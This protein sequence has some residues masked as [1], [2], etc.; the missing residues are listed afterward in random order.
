MNEPTEIGQHYNI[1]IEKAIPSD[2][3]TAIKNDQQ[4]YIKLL[5]SSDL[6]SV[7]IAVNPLPPTNYTQTYRYGTENPLSISIMPFLVSSHSGTKVLLG[8]EE[9]KYFQR[10]TVF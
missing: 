4:L 6:S 2:N 3:A 1:V 8:V 5:R 9:A 7:I 10:K